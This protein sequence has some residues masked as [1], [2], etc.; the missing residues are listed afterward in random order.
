MSETDLYDPI[1]KTLERLGCIVT[2]VH[3]G[4]VKVRGGWMQLADPG[5]PDHH[6]MAPN[7]IATWLET[8]TDEGSLSPAQLLWHER[9][10][11]SGHRVFVVRSPAEAVAAAYYLS[12]DR[13]SSDR[14]A[15]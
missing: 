3:S 10:K 8:K 14:E 12:G 11:R 4:K 2:R 15:E 13:L 7:G 5:T 6:V 1:K 9:A